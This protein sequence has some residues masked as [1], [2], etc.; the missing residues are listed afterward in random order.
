MTSAAARPLTGKGAK[1]ARAEPKA[2]VR[3]VVPPVPQK[4]AGVATKV[5]G[6]SSRK[7]R[8]TRKDDALSIDDDSELGDDESDE[9]PRKVTS[10]PPPPQPARS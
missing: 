1:P 6:P 3:I 2:T 7:Q 4:S 8:A 5:A 9:G 10:A